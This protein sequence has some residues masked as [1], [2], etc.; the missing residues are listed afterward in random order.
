[1]LKR[2]SKLASDLKLDEDYV[3]VTRDDWEKA[4]KII[5]DLKKLMKKNK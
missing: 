2:Y 3:I 4:Y 1:M 5:R